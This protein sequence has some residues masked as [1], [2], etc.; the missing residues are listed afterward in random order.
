VS[1]RSQNKMRVRTSAFNSR[2]ASFARGQSSRLLTVQVRLYASFL[3]NPL[4]PLWELSWSDQRAIIVRLVDSISGDIGPSVV[5]RGEVVHH[6]CPDNT[7]IQHHCRS[8]GMRMF[9]ATV[10]RYHHRDDCYRQIHAQH[11]VEHEAEDHHDV[12]YLSAW[13]AICK[14]IS[15]H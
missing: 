1:L 8:V 10:A 5:D 14:C 6:C 13:Q 7:F 3:T 15:G 2:E 4:E 11:V 9:I 12:Q